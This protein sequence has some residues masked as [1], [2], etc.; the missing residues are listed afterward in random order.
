ML[1]AVLGVLSGGFSGSLW[2]WEWV[3]SDEEIDRYRRSWNPFSHGPILHT[4]VDLQPKGQSL[5]R[6]F[7]FSQ[8]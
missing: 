1:L 3:P 6:P 8:K 2:A 7:I 4:A 5:L